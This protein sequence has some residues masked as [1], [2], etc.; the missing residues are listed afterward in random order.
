MKAVSTASGL[1][2]RVLRGAMLGTGSIAIHHMRAWQAI[3]GVEMVAL[4][5]RTRS[6]AEALA[7]ETGLESA[8][9]YSDYREL[10]A[11]ETL[12][13]VDVATAPF[14]HR[15]QVL[16]AAEAGIHA[17]C[18]KPFATSVDEA[19]E[20]IDACDQA[21]VRCVVN[22]NWRWRRWYRDLKQMLAQ[23]V[24]GEARYARIERR[25]AAL[26]PGSDS[27]KHQ[28]YTADLPHLLIFD[29]GIHFIDIM[30]F[31]FGDF[32]RVY[33]H[34]HC[35]NPL[36]KGETEAV[37][38]L[39]FEGKDLVGLIDMSAASYIPEEK[40]IIR[41]NLD[42]F[43]VVGDAG[44][45]ELNPYQ[46]DVIIITTSNGTERRPARPGLTP[47]EA[48]QESYFNTQSHFVHCLRTGQ[49]AEND[50]RDNLKTFSTTMAAYESAELREWV[51]LDPA[52]Q[53]TKRS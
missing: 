4:A 27:L 35:T 30:R 41:G 40:R 2:E 1:G 32:S 36:V 21:S 3:P 14:V 24:I 12:D 17:L 44:T 48:Y 31:L 19:L 23:G 52:R 11:N 51:K 50:A 33:A 10:L 16:A 42:C 26:L 46:D 5:N 15:E 13:F 45:I 20:M 25:S 53:L 37:V 18:Q 22:E 7:V 8:R 29:M 39:E 47:A 9:I 49:P 34:T 43:V 28:P 6:R 38:M